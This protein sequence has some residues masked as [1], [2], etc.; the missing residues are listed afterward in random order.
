MLHGKLMVNL[1]VPGISL[2]SCIKC[3]AWRRDL[4]YEVTNSE[5]KTGLIL[6][7]FQNSFAF[8]GKYKIEGRAR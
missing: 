8:F 5:N 3:L 2:Y 1:S 4:E 7:I 6:A